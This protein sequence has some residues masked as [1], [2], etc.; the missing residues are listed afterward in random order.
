MLNLMKMEMRTQRVVSVIAPAPFIVFFIMVVNSDVT[1]AENT[2]IFSLVTGLIAYMICL[3]AVFGTKEDER[4]HQRMRLSLPVSRA[5]IVRSKY[6]MI[7]AWWMFTYI[8]IF[9]CILLLS[10]FVDQRFLHF[11][12]LSSLLLSL[13][14]V[15]ILTGITYPLYY[16]FGQRAALIAS[17]CFIF[18][19]LL[20]SGIINYFFSHK[21]QK[22]T[23]E[24]M[25][26]AL[27]VAICSYSLSRR[28][29]L[30]KD[31]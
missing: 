10:L 2:L 3:Q 15:V 13:S 31:F 25:G 5:I 17:I 7:G 29:F 30:K 6:V 22:F 9:I 28:I 1:A 11:S 23:F 24:L 27:I 16:Q 20:L 19:L 26:I 18:M 12:L 14:T 4:L 21:L 8:L